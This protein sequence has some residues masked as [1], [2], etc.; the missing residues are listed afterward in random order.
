MIYTSGSTG[1][2]KGAVNTHAGGANRVLWNQ[3]QTPL[4]SADRLLQKTPLNFDVSVNEMF[5]P[6]SAGAQLV[7]ARPGGHR[8]SRLSRRRGHRRGD[9]HH[10]VRAVAPVGVSR[11]A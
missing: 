11:G 2:P 1:R 3:S 9:H 5:W 4:T 10:G 7:L 6:L 8:D